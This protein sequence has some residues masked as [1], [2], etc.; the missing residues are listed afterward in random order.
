MTN[1]T[2]NQLI[3]KPIYDKE[4]HKVGK[5]SHLYVDEASH[6]PTWA[7]VK[8]GFFGNKESFVP[9]TL[10]EMSE[11]DGEIIIMAEKD[12]ITNA[13]NVD[14]DG[15]LTPKEQAALYR[16]Y[17]EA[18]EHTSHKAEGDHQQKAEKKQ[19][20]NESDGRSESKQNEDDA[21][22]RYKEDLRAGK[23]TEEAGKVRLM[24]YVVTENATVTIPLSREKV[25]IVREPVTSENWDESGRGPAMTEDQQEVVLHQEVPTVEKETIPR[26]HVRMSKDQETT[27][28]TVNGEIRKERVDV[29]RQNTD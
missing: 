14:P 19:Q 2:A 26:E 15:E 7:T 13:P 18:E 23:K 21:M 22:T 11:G 1:V 12:V 28:R 6:R 3:G 24:K 5:L 17:H 25:R 8:T 4:L 9:L 20:P 29:D 27:K 10:A 16:Y